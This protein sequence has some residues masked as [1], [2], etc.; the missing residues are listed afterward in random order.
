MECLS[1]RGVAVI[2][3]CDFAGAAYGKMNEIVCEGAQV[4]IFVLHSDRY[5]GEIIT[6]GMDQAAIGIQ[7]YARGRACSANFLLRYLLSTGV[8]DRLQKAR[9]IRYLPD[10]SVLADEFSCVADVMTDWH[11]PFIAEPF[12]SAQGFSV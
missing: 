10:S 11:F 9:L 4:S 7:L 6:I 8:R 1:S 12:L 2:H 5:V 3:A